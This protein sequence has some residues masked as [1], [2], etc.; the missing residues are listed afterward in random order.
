MEKNQ[1]N[2]I[3]FWYKTYKSYKTYRKLSYTLHVIRYTLPAKR[4]RYWS[5]KVE[6]VEYIIS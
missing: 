3:M 1:L 5:C 2:L 4:N 6:R